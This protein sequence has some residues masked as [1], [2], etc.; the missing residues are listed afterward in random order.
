[1]FVCQIDLIM[2]KSIHGMIKIG[3]FG[4]SALLFCL[5]IKI[6][7]LAVN[8]SQT[9]KPT[10][11]GYVEIEKG[12][13]Y[14]QSFGKGPL[15]ILLHGGP[16]LDQSYLLPQM[17]E[18]AKDHQLI[19]YDQRGSGKSLTMDIFLSNSNI[20]MMQFVNDLEA[21]RAHLGRRKFILMGHSFGGLL[22][23]HYAIAHPDRVSSLIL[24]NPL[25]AT[26]KGLQTFITEYNRK[27]SQI[28]EQLDTLMSSKHFLAGNP[29]SIANFYRMLFSVYFY[30]PSQVT[31]LSLNFSLKSTV[32]YFNITQTFMENYFL[33]PIDL[34]PELK[35]IKCPTLIIAGDSDL[36][37]IST[38]KDITKA[39]PKS[40]VIMID[41]CGHFPYLEK[42]DYF[43]KAL[44]LF[45]EETSKEK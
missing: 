12:K 29:D 22:A 20:N 34:L 39:I 30:N 41:H 26:S 14:Y 18:L 16:G 44:S 7:A 11:E 36:I 8:E 24:L 9:I 3:L 2:N 40:K 19:L 32:N 25:P 5:P 31:K 15:I 13:L 28:K 38:V 42:P 27:I 33:K 4:F 10:E 43:F 21:L 17:L 1:M 45:L 6:H 35:R 23:M 37:P